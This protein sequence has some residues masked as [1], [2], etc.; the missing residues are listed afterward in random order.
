MPT[1]GNGVNRKLE[2]YATGSIRKLEAYATGSIRKLEAYAT[3]CEPR[4]RPSVRRLRRVESRGRTVAIVRARV[5][6]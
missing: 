4:A 6:F 5:R 2:A 1:R 3:T